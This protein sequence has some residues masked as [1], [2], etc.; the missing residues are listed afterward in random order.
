MADK[1][2]KSLDDI[3]SS[4]RTARRTSQRR[5]DTR[6]TRASHNTAPVGGVKKTVR[7]A[8]ST[9]KSI[10][11]GPSMGLGESKIIVSGLPSDVGEANIK[12]W[13][14]GHWPDAKRSKLSSVSISRLP[15]TRRLIWQLFTMSPEPNGSQVV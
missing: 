7:N 5:R 6:S 2:D 3:L 10:P 4:R 14:A 11:T 8:K 1:L 13:L 12:L 9:S 15:C